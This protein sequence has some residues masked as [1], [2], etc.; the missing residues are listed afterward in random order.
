MR[1][2][3]CSCCRT[4]RE[5]VIFDALPVDV[6]VLDAMG[7]IVCASSGWRR[8]AARFLALTGLPTD[9]MD[10]GSNYVD[11]LVAGL[12]AA[13]EHTTAARDGILAVLVGRETRFSMEHPGDEAAGVHWFELTVSRLPDGGGAIVVHSDITDRKAA[14]L[15]RR[16]S[17]LRLQLA[18]DAIGDG[19]WDWDVPR[20]VAY[21]S[22]G[23][24]ALTGLGPGL[25]VID[26][27]FFQR[28]I[29]VDDRSSVLEQI[30][31]NL[32]GETANL[33]VQFRCVAS[34]GESRW[35]RGRGR[36]VERNSQNAP[37]RMIGHITDIS[38]RKRN[39]QRQLALLDE[40]SRLGRELIRVQ[41]SERSELAREIHDEL[42][43]QLTAIRAYAGAIRRNEAGADE[44]TRANAAA[45]EHSAS[46]VYAVS[47]RIMEGLHP[48]ILNI[49]GLVQALQ[50]LISGWAESR[51]SIRFTFR[52]AGQSEVDDRE[53]RLHL[54][55]IAQEF[56]ANLVRHSQARRARVFLGERHH[57]GRRWLRLIVRDD[58]IG[59]PIDVPR[60][61][62]GLVVVRER[63]RMLDGR[64]TVDGEF[65][66]GVRV[67]VE[68]PVGDG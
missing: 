53:V 33:D 27:A 5:C 28:L 30:N 58:G 15:S 25:V 22:P 50:T 16:S 1:L 62:Y 67:A 23:Y 60:S 61:G 13:S 29:F 17:E 42:S 46:Q 68:V 21:L 8:F 26:D 39:E 56:L 2:N 36:V 55:R 24:H 51:S 47:H 49:V 31:A 6:A 19:L 64:F 41:E 20:G 43:Q 48:Q 7:T 11:L 32:C 4:G 44:R 57:D 52:F 18:L 45:I 12:G 63:A 40:N 35:L 10:V 59:M 3:G 38:D 37:L 54:F 66:Q 34:R 9:R 14:E 65:G